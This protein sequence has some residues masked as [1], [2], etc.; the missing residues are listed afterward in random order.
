MPVQMTKGLVRARGCEA[1]NSFGVNRD[2]APV[3]GV[4][5]MTEIVLERCDYSTPY[6]ARWVHISGTQSQILAKINEIHV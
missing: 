4:H 1:K 3:S 5:G 6:F 2:E